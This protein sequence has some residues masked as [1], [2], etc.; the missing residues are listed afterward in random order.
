MAT[1]SDS[2]WEDFF[3][4]LVKLLDISENYSLNVK[5]D[6]PSAASLFNPLTA[7]WALR[8]LIDF[9][10]SNARRFFDFTRQ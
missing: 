9:T 2:S 7:E 10:L 1:V 6:F 8:A 5:L 3:S 4:G